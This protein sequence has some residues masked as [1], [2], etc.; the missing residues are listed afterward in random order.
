MDWVTLDQILDDA[1]YISLFI[2]AW[3]NIM[4]TSLLSQAMNK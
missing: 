2:N 1:L 4:N 3:G